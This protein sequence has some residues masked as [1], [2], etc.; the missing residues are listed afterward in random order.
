MSKCN[1][2][3]FL[4]LSGGLALALSIPSAVFNACKKE[5]KM[6]SEASPVI[7]IQGQS[8]S[9]CSV[10]LLNSTK[11]DI[12]T[13]I[14]KFIS[15]N[16]HQTMSGGTGDSLINVLKDAVDKKRSD[17]ILIVEGSI[18]KKSKEYCTL[19]RYRNKHMGVEDW[20][21]KL[22]KRAKAII[23]V[24]ACATY[25]GIPAAKGNKTGAI[26]LS[27]LFPLRSIVNIPGCPTHPD[28]VIGSLINILLKG[29][30]ALDEYK[31]PKIYFNKTVH[32]LCEHLKDYEKGNFAEKWGDDGCQY[33]LGCLGIDTNC[34]I[35]K[36]KW[37]DS[38]TCTAS[39]SGCIG[40][41]EEPFPDFG[42]RGLYLNKT[43]H[44][45]TDN[46]TNSTTI[47]KG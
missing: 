47:K 8:C 43:A 24:G 14:T 40:C 17:F 26:P 41:T 21:V 4:Q 45:E 3:E 10:S 22:G 36:R 28:W 35:P 29:I 31:R 5:I 6:A 7:W 39:G 15:L 2:R 23:A 25:G 20:I 13:L 12:T 42:N 9:G 27:K 46:K 19:G 33:K 11:P 44:N 30:P 37:L 1:R 18:P 38:N 32:T 16:F 34:D